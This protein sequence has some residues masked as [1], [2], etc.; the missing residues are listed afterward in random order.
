MSQ[1]TVSTKGAIVIPQIIRKKYGIRPTS[2]VEVLD[3]GG[4]VMI[5]PVPNDPIRAAR[6]FLKFKDSA[7][8]ALRKT[9][10]EELK[11]DHRRK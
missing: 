4:R 11:Y 3:I 8:T 5:L 7:L 10:R 1:V 9:R 2:H 6:G